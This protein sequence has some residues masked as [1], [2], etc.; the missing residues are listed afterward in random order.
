M[1]TK[2]Q[3]KKQKIKEETQLLNAKRKLI[4]DAEAL[5]DLL[6]LIPT[7]RYY[8]KNGINAEIKAYNCCPKE[9]QEWV[10]KI[11]EAHMKGFYEATWGWSERNKRQELTE[12]HARYLIAI[13][14]KRPIGFIHFRFEFERKMV[15]LYIYELHIENAYHRKGLGRF[16]VQAT[17]LIALKCKMEQIITTVFKENVGSVQLFNKLNYKLH[18]TSPELDEPDCMDAQQISILCKSLVREPK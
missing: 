13:K 10:Y 12:D 14:N 8:D 2:A 3:L 6:D 11:T 17:E 15:V 4:A 1:A 18:P 5:P 16:L 7:F 9:Y